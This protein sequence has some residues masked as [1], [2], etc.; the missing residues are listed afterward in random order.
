VPPHSKIRD[1]SFFSRIRLSKRHSDQPPMNISVSIFWPEWLPPNKAA[2]KKVNLFSAV[3]TIMRKMS[4]KLFFL[5]K[6][7]II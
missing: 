4:K 1:K 7:L 3:P 2:L 6:Y 5:V